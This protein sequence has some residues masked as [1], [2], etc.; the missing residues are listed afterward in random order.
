MLNK[1]KGDANKILHIPSKSQNTGGLSRIRDSRELVLL[2]HEGK[3]I[4]ARQPFIMNNACQA[5][6][7]NCKLQIMQKSPGKGK[8]SEVFVIV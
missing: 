7:S 5:T 6:F 8:G 3:S 2:N 1:I 4:D